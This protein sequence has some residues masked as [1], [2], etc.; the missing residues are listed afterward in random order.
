MERRLADPSCRDV[1]PDTATSDPCLPSC[2]PLPRRSCF[3]Y[4]VSS[5][6]FIWFTVRFHARPL[7]SCFSFLH[8]CMTFAGSFKTSLSFLLVPP[9]PPSS[10]T[11]SLPPKTLPLYLCP[12]LRVPSRGRVRGLPTYR[13][14]GEAPHATRGTMIYVLPLPS[15]LQ[16]FLP[17]LLYSLTL[18]ST[19]SQ[20]SFLGKSRSLIL[21]LLLS[22][23]HLVQAPSCL[24]FIIYLRILPPPYYF[25]LSV[26]H[27]FYVRVK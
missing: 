22:L 20:A 11:P 8:G 25:S 12:S 4:C 18:S 9:N 6:N 19:T 2:F 27:F 24:L 17:F 15:L 10:L 23:L 5:H 16:P 21:S 3:I 13:H 26:Y 1:T 14:S 7:V